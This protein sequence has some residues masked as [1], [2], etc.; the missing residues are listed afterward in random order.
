MKRVTVWFSCGA[1][2]ACAAKLALTE[3]GTRYPVDIIYCDTSIDEHEDN[4]RFASDVERWLGVTIKHLHSTEYSGV[5]DV[6]E[7]TRYFAGKDGA[8]CTTELKK[9]PRQEYQEPGDLHVWGYTVEEFGRIVRFKANNPEAKSYFILAGQGMTK[10]DCKLM[11]TAAGIELPVMYGLGFNNN[12]CIACGKAES[13]PY[14]QRVRHY[15]PEKFRQRC[16]QSRRIGWRPLRIKRKR[17][18]LDELP[19]APEGMLPTITEDISCGP[20]CGTETR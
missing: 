12:N 9:K 3:F 19:P 17:L 8:R 16:E 11:I 6:I 10:E 14:W 4:K 13:V 18:Y 2:S 20:V 5:D 7:K 15:F 1:P